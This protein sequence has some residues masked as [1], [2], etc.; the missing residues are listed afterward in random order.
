MFLFGHS[1]IP[2]IKNMRVYSMKYIQ[3]RELVRENATTYTVRIKNTRDTTFQRRR[4]GRRN[5]LKFGTTN[6][7]YFLYFKTRNLFLAKR[8]RTMGLVDRRLARNNSW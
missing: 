5:R 4:R 2:S 3:E 1:V 8:V 7:T 6:N